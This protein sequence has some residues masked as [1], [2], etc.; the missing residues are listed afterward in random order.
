MAN[1]IQKLSVAAD[2]LAA[3]RYDPK[4]MTTQRRDEIGF[5]YRAFADMAEKLRHRQN[6]L[7]TRVH[8]R[9]AELQETGVVLKKTQQAAV[10]S[11]Q[12]ASMGQ[13]AA[14]VAHEIRTPLTSLKLFLESVEN[15]IEVSPEFE[16]D[17]H[18][19][20]QQIKRMEDTKSFPGFCET[21]GAAFF[22]YLYRGS[23]QRC[24]AGGWAQGQTAG[25]CYRTGCG[26]IAFKHKGRQKTALRGTC[27]SD[28]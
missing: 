25:D 7:E 1:P 13:L 18:V 10:R 24:P 16:E 9:E 5:L 12:L 17:F 14:G 23:D 20:M 19:A 4:L 27:Q 2:E 15:D 3:G 26:T 28:G 21:T 8:L 22:G 6:E 11:Q